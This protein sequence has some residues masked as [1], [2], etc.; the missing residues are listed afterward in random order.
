MGTVYK[1][2]QLSTTQL[3]ALKVLRAPLWDDPRARERFEQEA[4][5]VSKIVSEHLVKVIAA[6]ID[7]EHGAPWIA[8]EFLEG[9]TLRKRVESRGPY[10]R[11]E[12][13]ELARQLCHALGAAHDAGVVHRDLKPENIF[14]A[15]SARAGERETVKLLDFGIATALEEFETSATITSVIGSPLWM[16]PEQVRRERIRPATDVWALGL[17]MFW[18]LTAKPYW[19]HTFPAD[20]VI[21]EKMVEPLVLAS[22]RA[23][24]FACADAIPPGFDPWFARC[25]SRKIDERFK[26]AS[27]AFDAFERVMTDP[28]MPRKL[29]LSR[30]RW[31]VI[32]ALSAL[33][34][35]GAVW[36]ARSWLTLLPA[37][38]LIASPDAASPDASTRGHFNARVLVASGDGSTVDAVDARSWPDGN[39]DFD[40]EFT[41]ESAPQTALAQPAVVAVSHH[42]THVGNAAA[43][44]M[45]NVVRA[46]TSSA[47]MVPGFSVQAA[48]GASGACRSGRASQP[49]KLVPEW[50]LQR[51]HTLNFE[52]RLRAIET[53]GQMAAR[54]EDPIAQR[55]ASENAA[56][57]RRELD[58]E[59]AM[60]A[61][62]VQRALPNLSTTLPRAAQLARCVHAGLQSDQQGLYA[63]WCCP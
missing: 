52:Q 34:G 4:M 46:T 35:S 41:E 59:R 7:P 16:A 61:D 19:R 56:R 29:P 15:K 39:S 6:G 13:V 17:L 44:Q 55:S 43:H 18:A 28:R 3:R 58:R 32:A 53:E 42:T 51:R 1:V 63:I 21:F 57:R 27:E 10:G 12:A 23:A 37:S 11:L 20:A 62:E 47:P 22:E 30:T 2:E 25:V 50:Y 8:M 60:L 40:A 48:P 26:D 14:I 49:F 54:L 9:E 45:I 38:V 5:V 33:A 31:A 36:A 24:E